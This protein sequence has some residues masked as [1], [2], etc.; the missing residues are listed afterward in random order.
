MA[1]AEVVVVL[2]LAVDGEA[3]TGGM[4]AVPVVMGA[5]VAASLGTWLEIAVRAVVVAEPLVVAVL[6]AVGMATWQGPAL[7]GV[8]V[9]VEVVAEAAATSVVHLGIWLGTVLLVE[10]AAALALAIA[11]GL[12][13]TWPGIAAAVVGMAV[14][15]EEDDMDSA[16]D[17]VVIT[18]GNQGILLRSVLTLLMPRLE[19]NKREERE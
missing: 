10:E 19:E 8:S 15:V 9:V 1:V 3:V 7:M 14:L 12:M 18:V 16:L 5:I 13:A 6:L 17:Q 11:V 2:D 4:G